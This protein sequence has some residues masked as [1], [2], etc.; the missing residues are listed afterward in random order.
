MSRPD[1][2]GGSHAQYKADTGILTT[3]L[4]ETAKK[5]GLTLSSAD[6]L[7][8]TTLGDT[9]KRASSKQTTL[10]ITVNQ[11]VQQSRHI[12]SQHPKVPVPHDIFS[13]AKHA[14]RLRSKCAAWFRKTLPGTADAMLQRQN[15]WHQHFID[16]MKDILRLLEPNLSPAID[17]GGTKQLPANLYELLDYDNTLESYI[18]DTQPKSQP[19]TGRPRPSG[20]ELE[21]VR[22]VEE[23]FLR[24]QWTLLDYH[25]IPQYVKKHMDTMQVG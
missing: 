23:R 2:L 20:R 18:E 22:N 11:L 7:I 12:T 24:I 1:W 10:H 3:W 16:N 21:E 4:A 6:K 13:A 14:I 15:A 9:T 19:D 5:T 25:S 17:S 8:A